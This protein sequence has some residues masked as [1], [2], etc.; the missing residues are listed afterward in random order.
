[1]SRRR[2]EQEADA[3]IELIV[4]SLTDLNGIRKAAVRRTLVK[5][6]EGFAKREL[7]RNTPHSAPR[8]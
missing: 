5:R 4:G 8:T 1:M 2:Y 6:L 3:I 7:R